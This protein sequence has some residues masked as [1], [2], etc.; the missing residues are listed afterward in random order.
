VFE[1]AADVGSGVAGLVDGVELGGSGDRLEVLARL[2]LVEIGEDPDR[3]GLRDTPA[4]YARWWREFMG[5]DAGCTTTT[6]ER[7]ASGQMVVVSGV[8]VWSLCEHH[9]L[10][11]SCCLTIAY[12][13]QEHLVGISKFAR[14][15]HG[16]AHGLQVQER[17]VAQIADDVARAAHAQ[18]V[19][20]VGRGEHLCMTMRG[21]RARADVTTT[22]FLGCFAADAS[23]RAE[24]LALSRGYQAT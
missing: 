3:D 15:A 4:R 18:D 13:P 2:L 12:K 1:L 14:I 5:Y 17:L 11:F 20:V 10:P 7:V 23:A 9:L 19:A 21:I 8:T 22:S 16:R 24:L 6:F